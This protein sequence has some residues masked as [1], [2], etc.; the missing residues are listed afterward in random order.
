VTRYI[1]PAPRVAAARGR[2]HREPTPSPAAPPAQRDL[3]SPAAR[4]SRRDERQLWIPVGLLLVVAC[5][6]M[7]RSVYAGLGGP[8]LLAMCLGAFSN[9]FSGLALVSASQL[10]PDPDWSS[11]VSISSL[12]FAGWAATTLLRMAV[13]HRPRLPMKAL[14]LIVPVTV[15]A[16]IAAITHGDLYIPN[17]LA[18][19]GLYIVLFYDLFQRARCDVRRCTLAVLGGCCTAAFGYWAYRWGVDLV[20]SAV[21]STGAIADLSRGWARIEFGRTDSNTIAVNISTIL[22]GIVAVVMSRGSGVRRGSR[23]AAVMSLGVAGMV[24]AAMVPALAGTMSRGGLAEL[25]AG[26][27]VACLWLVVAPRRGGKRRAGTVIGLVVTALVVASALAFTPYGAETVARIVET[28]NFTAQQGGLVAA[29]GVTLRGTLDTVAGAPL[30]GVSYQE[31][32]DR[33]GLIPHSSFFDVS[34]GAG[35]PGL[36]LFVGCVA[37]PFALAIR[38]GAWREL[39]LPVFVA[40]VCFVVYAGTISAL[41]NKTFWCLWFLCLMN[42]EGRPSDPRVVR[43]SVLA[44]RRL[45][46]S[47]PRT[48]AA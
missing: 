48:R 46:A 13:G 30:V 38:R 6:V 7:V 18:R 33:Y 28:Q 3:R 16:S 10:V 5:A 35:L 11:G 39:Y 17:L 43:R 31:F 26:L 34:V 47:L 12:V 8:L 27:A 25:G 24:G 22:A 37:S 15:W 20:V 44:P 1:P 9:P 41:S 2:V 40:Y 14:R 42:V 19:D 4:N 36:L 21:D 45:P 29:R 23:G 32:V